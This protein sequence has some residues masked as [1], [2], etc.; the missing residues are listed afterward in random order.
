[1]AACVQPSMHRPFPALRWSAQRDPPAATAATQ[2]CGAAREAKPGCPLCS[3]RCMLLLSHPRAC[4]MCTMQYAISDAQHA[5]VDRASLDP[6]LCKRCT[7]WSRQ[8]ATQ[9]VQPVQPVRLCATRLGTVQQRWA[10]YAVADRIWQ[11]G[12]RMPAVCMGAVGEM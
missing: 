10:P 4:A 2:R 12:L 11:F 5:A 3:S 8:G 9:P 7:L 6:L 1:M